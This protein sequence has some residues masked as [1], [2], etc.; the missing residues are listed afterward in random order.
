MAMIR[1][2]QEPMAEEHSAEAAYI[3]ALR[4]SVGSPTG[5]ATAPAL[6]ATQDSSPA[7]NSPDA[8]PRDLYTGGEKRGSVRYKCEGTIE[9]HEAGCQAPTCAIV[10]DV[11]M[12]GCYVDTHA[13]YPV[14]KA[15]GLKLD[16]NG[17]AV[18]A[19]GVVRVNYPYLGMGISFVEVPEENKARLR[20]ILR[21]ALHPPAVN[22][23]PKASLGAVPATSDSAAAIHALIEFF[24]ENQMLTREGFLRILWSNAGTPKNTD[25]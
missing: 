5:A 15:L 6:E 11:S 12:H 13:T 2:P 1:P 14:G 8:A 16:V 22:D 19:N 7:E 4:H 18:Q 24:Q 10:T 9:M 3:T 20:E 17:I 25:A 21:I 23:S